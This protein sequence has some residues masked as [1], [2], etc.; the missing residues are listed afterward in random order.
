MDWIMMGWE[1]IFRRSINWRSDEALYWI[2]EIP[3]QARY[4]AAVR[5]HLAISLHNNFY[6]R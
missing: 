3:G 1:E 5:W 6:Y 2:V 4:D